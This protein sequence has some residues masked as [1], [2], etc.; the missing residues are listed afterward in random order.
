MY[1]C[2]AQQSVY[3][4]LTLDQPAFLSLLLT[5][6][7]STPILYIIVILFG[8]P[9]TTHQPHTLLLALHVALLTTPQLYY[10]HGLEAESWFKVVSLQ[11]PVDEV[12]GM[13]LGAC[14]G[15]LVGAIPIPLDWDREWQRWPVTI[16]VG[17]Y[18]GAVVG[19]VLGGHVC[20]GLVIKL[21]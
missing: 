14:V 18:F 2:P 4:S 15:A 17:L 5:L 8:A 19:K 12:F 10:T 11:L 16:V 13:T 9:L 20:K 7:L 1:V 3:N 6:F 21:S